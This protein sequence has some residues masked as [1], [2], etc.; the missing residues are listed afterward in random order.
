MKKDKET[1]NAEYGLDSRYAS[2]EERKADGKILMAAHL[3]RM[4]NVSPNLII[5]A[6]LLSLELRMKEYGKSK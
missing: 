1:E 5:Q 6:E 4:K 2:D 3:E